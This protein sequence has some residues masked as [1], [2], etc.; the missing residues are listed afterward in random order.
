MSSQSPTRDPQDTRDADHSNQPT[1][2]CRAQRLTKKPS[3]SKANG[4]AD[5]GESYA[6]YKSSN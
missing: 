6:T 2:E 1:P 3:S 5:D 4:N